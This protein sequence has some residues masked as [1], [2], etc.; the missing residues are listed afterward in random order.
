MLT[1]YVLVFLLGCGVGAVFGEWARRH[2]QRKLAS[3]ILQA[4]ESGELVHQ[5]VRGPAVL[6]EDQADDLR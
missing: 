6:R 5:P 2:R 4:M 1:T 3:D